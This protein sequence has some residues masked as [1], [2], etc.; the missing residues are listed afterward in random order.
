MGVYVLLWVVFVGGFFCKFMKMLGFVIMK[1]VLKFRGFVFKV[2][3]RVKEE[4][5]LGVL[6]F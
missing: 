5:G 3:F 4:R 1:F 6:F 2:L